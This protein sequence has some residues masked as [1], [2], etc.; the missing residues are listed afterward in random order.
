MIQI[1]CIAITAVKKTGNQFGTGKRRLKECNLPMKQITPYH[2]QCSRGHIRRWP[3]QEV[4][5]IKGALLPVIQIKILKVAQKLV[6]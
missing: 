6:S 5:R 3:P 1:Q 2:W 4:E